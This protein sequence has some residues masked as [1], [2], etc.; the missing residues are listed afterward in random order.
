MY[1]LDIPVSQVKARIRTEFERFA[2]VSDVKV[3]QMLVIKG[4]MELDE[5]CPLFSLP[6]F[7]LV[8]LTIFFP[9]L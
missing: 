5:V 7:F 4:H 6:P 3:A 9:P 8:L 2:D 1:L